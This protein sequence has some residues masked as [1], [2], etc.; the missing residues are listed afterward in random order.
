MPS[1]LHFGSSAKHTNHLRLLD[2]LLR[3]GVAQRLAEASSLEAAFKVLQSYYSLGP[4]LAFQFT[5]DLNYGPIL[6]FDEMDFVVPGPG[7]RDGIR[8]CFVDL[9]DFTEADTIRYITE[10]QSEFFSALGLEFRSLWG[11]PLQLIDCQNLFCEIAKYARVAH[12]EIRGL[13]DRHR[14]K[15]IFRPSPL[16]ELPMYPPK[17]GLTP[18]VELPLN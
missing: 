4:F 11:R 1:A 6:N 12:P 8:K 16:E 9:G 3:Q 17:W 2:L 7:A 15:H 5:I 18:R 13:S 10:H 14:I